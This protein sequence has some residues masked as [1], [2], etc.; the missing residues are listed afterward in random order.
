MDRVVKFNVYYFSCKSTNGD[1]LEV[2]NIVYS[3]ELLSG[4]DGFINMFC[5]IFV[6]KNAYIALFCH[7]FSVNVHLLY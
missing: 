7:S 5:V 3:C 4:F 2:I 1:T 6:V